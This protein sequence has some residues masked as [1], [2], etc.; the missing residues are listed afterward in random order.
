M[1]GKT[2]GSLTPCLPAT[3]QRIHLVIGADRF[4]R[5][6]RFWSHGLSQAILPV[7]NGKDQ[8][9]FIFTKS[10][11]WAPEGAFILMFVQF[12][13]PMTL[14]PYA[15]WNP[16]RWSPH[17]HRRYVL[18]KWGLDPIT[19]NRIHIEASRQDMPG[20]Q[21]AFDGVLT[22][23]ASSAARGFNSNTVLV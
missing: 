20:L 3:H 4:Q 8:K 11:S 18:M 9:D 14:G 12:S 5:S 16:A 6:K 19:F 21:Y 23:S 13:A 1:S 10:A 15:F 22:G 17:H 2:A 7:F